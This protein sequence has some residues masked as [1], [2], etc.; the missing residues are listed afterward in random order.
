M[1]RV[2]SASPAV[3]EREGEAR[4]KARVVSKTPPILG[5][6]G[7]GGAEGG[8]GFRFSTSLFI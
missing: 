8:G 3:C 1:R 5:I 2:L 7:S 4:S 6:E